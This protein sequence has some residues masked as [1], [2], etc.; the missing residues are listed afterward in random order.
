MIESFSLFCLFLIELTRQTCARLW[1]ALGAHPYGLTA[2]ACGSYRYCTPPPAHPSGLPYSFQRPWHGE[3]VFRQTG[4]LAA[5]GCASVVPIHVAPPYHWPDS[6]RLAQGQTATVKAAS[7]PLHEPPTCALST[8]GPAEAHVPMGG[9]GMWIG[10][11]Q[12]AKAG[13][14]AFVF[15]I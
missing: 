6:R 2:A 5:S 15:Y 14:E 8:H 12:W 4:P 7:R 13:T 10:I 3:T 9:N 11:F 1:E